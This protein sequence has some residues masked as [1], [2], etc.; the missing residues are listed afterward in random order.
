MKY[1]TTR[2]MRKFESEIASAGE[3]KDISPYDETG[4]EEDCDDLEQEA[5][6]VVTRISS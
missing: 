1:P 5:A 2:A 3:D 4:F 6:A